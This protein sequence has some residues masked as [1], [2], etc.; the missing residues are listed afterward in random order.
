MKYCK[1]CNETKPLFD[2]AFKNKAKGTYQW[3]CNACRRETAKKH[4]ESNREHII[5]RSTSNNR[6]R[7]DW[8]KELKQGLSCCV[9]G[10]D[11]SACLDFHHIDPSTKDFEISGSGR[12]IGRQTLIEEMNKCACLCANCHRK[13]HAGKLDA[14]LVKLEITQVYEI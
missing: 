14:P 10:E 3:Q 6:K 9:C 11:E 5:K 4:Y 8:L 7:A 1:S 13:H 2:F 12:S